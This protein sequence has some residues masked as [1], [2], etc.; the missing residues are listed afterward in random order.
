MRLVNQNGTID[1]P[2]DICAISLG[3]HGSKHIIYIRSKLFDDKFCAFADYS[4]EAKALKAMEMLRKQY[5]KFEVSKV[6]A[7]GSAEVMSKKLTQPK[8]EETISQ[9]WDITIFQ[10]PKDEEIEV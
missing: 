1:V 6:I 8:V 10:F 5:S 4:T 9:F 2:Y 3:E 7:C